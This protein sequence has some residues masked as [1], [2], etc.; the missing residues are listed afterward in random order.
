MFSEPVESVVLK[1][2]EN[3]RYNRYKGA[4]APVIIIEL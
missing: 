2:M 4:L 1:S 3:N